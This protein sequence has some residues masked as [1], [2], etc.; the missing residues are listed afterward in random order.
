[1]HALTPHVS[2]EQSRKQAK[3]LL[4]AF[5]AG[6]SATLDRI[7]WNHPHFRGLRDAEITA[8]RFVL[9][10]AQLVVARLHYFASWPKLLEHVETLR[11]RD[12]AVLRFENAADAVIEG[13]AERLADML[14]A[15]PE[16]SRQRS[17]RAH[18]A[19][20]LHYVAANGVEDYR[21]KS[22]P[23]APGIADILLGA[24]AEV[25]ATSEAYGGGSTALGLVAT[26]TPPRRAGVQI[27]IIDRLLAAGA[28]IV[29]VRP[30]ADHVATALANGCPEAAR[31][32]VERG[33]PLRGVA[34]AA[35]VGDL[36]AVRRLFGA[37]EPRQ[38]ERALVAAASHGTVEVVE[39]L[40]DAGVP[41]DAHDGMTAL[42]VAA[43][44]GA[45]PIIDLLIGRGAPLE[46]ENQ[47]GGTVLDGVLWHAYHDDPRDAPTRDYA[48]VLDVLI[49]AGARTDVYPEMATY[50]EEVRR[51]R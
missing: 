26:S 34:P 41:V 11:R 28:S 38:R 19:P 10:D 9:A 13:D 37:A 18:G 42:H 12:P 23:N 25:D 51:R 2:L 16:L 4:K 33:A 1:M 44:R 7:R 46:K 40:L 15:H 6:D 17:S 49:A 3:D 36:A 5:R 47:F 14:G 8:G 43:A 24:D 45:L 50:V 30:D 31:A 22:P 32:L 35:G 20:L 39:Y 48:A 21:Q 29:G 27:Q